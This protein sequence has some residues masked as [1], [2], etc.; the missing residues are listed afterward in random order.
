MDV[1]YM[2]I[3]MKHS[4]INSFFN[5]AAMSAMLVFSL[6]IQTSNGLANQC[7]G[8]DSG[9]CEAAAACSW[10]QGYERKDGRKVSAFCRTKAKRTKPKTDAKSASK[11]SG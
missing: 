4:K 9:D 11:T 10:V 5:R 2:E 8:L 1:T 3:L 7:K 6:M